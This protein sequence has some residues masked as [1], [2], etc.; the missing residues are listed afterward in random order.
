MSTNRRICGPTK[1]ALGTAEHTLAI[2]HEKDRVSHSPASL[3]VMDA[4]AVLAPVVLR[5]VGHQFCRSVQNLDLCEAII[6][7]IFY[8]SE[9]SI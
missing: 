9:L 2:S 6:S 8:F 7:G 5:V 3:A 1:V 4:K